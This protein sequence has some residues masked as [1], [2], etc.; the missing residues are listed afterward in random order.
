[1]NIVADE[2]MP[3]AEEIFS[4]TGTVKRVPGRTLCADDLAGADMLLVRSVTQVN[5]ALLKGTDLRFVGTATIGTDHVDT[6]YLARQHIPFSS[7]PGCNADAVV[8]YV[9][10]SLFHLAQSQGFDPRTRTYGIVGVGNVGSRL[11]Q[12]LKA[13]GYQVLLNDPLRAAAGEEGFVE[14]DE[15]LAEAD[16]V[17]L[18]TPLTKSGVS[19]SYHLLDEARLEKLKPGVIL[20]NAGRGPVIDNRALLKVK[21]QRD[22]LTLVLDVWEHEPVVDP[23]LVALT[24]IATPHIAGYSYDGKIRGTFMLYEACCHALGLPVTQR[25][26]DFLPDPEINE[27]RVTSDVSALALIRLRY[28]P[29]SDDRALRHGLHLSA[30]ARAVAFDQLRKH[31]ARRREYRSLTIRGT[32][33][34]TQKQQL[35]AIG[36]QIAGDVDII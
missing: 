21:Q 16:V 9:L 36:F 13:L 6:E 35:S 14:L 24:E 1:M 33:S 23:A 26:D 3:L 11:H 4:E 18:H 7:A 5:P 27:V 20:L 19:P 25:L 8:E 12:R 17:C 29:Y 22:D 32:L 34:G 10:S 30:E 15:L 28:D 31:Y 2:N